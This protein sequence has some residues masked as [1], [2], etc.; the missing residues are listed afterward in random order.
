MKVIGLCGGSGSGKGS[1]AEFF[2]AY[3]IHSVDTDMVYREITSAG[4]KCLKALVSQFGDSIIAAD[5]SLDRSRLRTLVF[6]GDGAEDRRLILNRI[7]HK[8]ILDRT[9]EIL[10]GFKKRGDVAAIVDAPL[11]FESGFNKKCDIILAVIADEE[12]RINRIIGRDGISIAEAKKRIRSQISND[13][14]MELSDYHIVNNGNFSE[15]EEQVRQI[16]EQI[17]N[18]KEVN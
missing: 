17:I 10:C 13:R 1:V 2:K 8:F 5:G 6:E 14:L 4:G 3:G 18:S 7:S 12:V 16:A 15:L 11:L 9:E